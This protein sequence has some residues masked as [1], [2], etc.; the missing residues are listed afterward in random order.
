MSRQVWSIFFA[1]ALSISSLAN[2]QSRTPDG[3]W[4]LRGIEATERIV[5][6][7]PQS[8]DQITATELRFYIEGLLA[9]NRYA[10]TLSGLHTALVS[11]GKDKTHNDRMRKMVSLYTPFKRMAALTYG[12]A[13]TVIKKQLLANPGDMKAD[14]ILVVIDAFE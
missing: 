14:A 4:L 8:N 1:I 5:L 7:A 6:G 13:L 12:Q 9:M 11:S 2:A 10:N 3:A